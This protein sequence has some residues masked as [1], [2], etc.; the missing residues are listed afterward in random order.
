MNASIIATARGLLVAV[1]IA[2][3]S[4]GT[5]ATGVVDRLQSMMGGSKG[6]FTLVLVDVTGS[7]AAED[8]QLYERSIA[9]LLEGTKPGDRVVMAQVSDRPGSRFMAHADLSL[10]LTGNSMHDKVYAKRTRDAFLNEFRQLRDGSQRNA[11][12]TMLLDAMGASGEWFAQGRANGQVLRLLVLSDM[13]EES[14]A[15]N[16]MRGAPNREQTERSIALQRQRNLLPDLTGV[17][18]HVVGASGRD[19]AHMAGIREFWQAYF[20]AS[21]AT[22]QSYGRSPGLQAP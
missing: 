6:S 1:A 16:F 20:T 8:W 7:I 17:L 3:A 19:T 13:I 2:L 14:S 12:A 5:Q 15:G 22:L 11:K 4:A 9:K 10:K 21:G 18:V